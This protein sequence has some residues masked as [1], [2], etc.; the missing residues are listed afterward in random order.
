MAGRREAGSEAAA[1]ARQMVVVLT[2]ALLVGGREATVSKTSNGKTGQA[3][4]TDRLEVF[5][6][7]S[8]HI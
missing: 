8:L 6:A 1:A 7:W 2:T 4:I 5:R 3:H